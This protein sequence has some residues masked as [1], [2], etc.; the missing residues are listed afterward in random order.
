MGLS[1]PGITTPKGFHAAAGCCGIKPSGKPDLA[2][3][4]ADQPCS[5]A[6]VFTTNR[7]PSPSV[8]VAKRHVRSGT[9][10]AVVCNS[11][12]SNAATGNAGYADAVAMCRSVSQQA[13]SVAGRYRDV[14]PCSTGVIGPRLPMGKIQH[15][16]E[17]LAS[18]LGR[19][20]GVNDAVA[21]AIMTTDLSPK[22]AYTAVR[23]GG[24][25]GKLAR[26]GA[27]AK[28]SGMIAPNMATMLAFL[29][30][31]AAVAPRALAE[32]LRTAVGES[33]NRISIDQHTSPSDTVLVLAS[34][35][36]KHPRIQG[37][38]ADLDQ[39]TAALTDV[40]RD[41][42]YQIVGDGEGATKIFRVTVIG[43]KSLK[44][45]DRVGRTV[46]NSP[47]VKTAV[48]GGDPNWGR[49]V[50]AAGYSGAVIKPEK[51]SLT[52]GPLARASKGGRVDGSRSQRRTTARSPKN[53]CVYDQGHATPVD[54]SGAA[55]LERVM[56]GR[57]IEFTLDLGVGQAR[58]QWL[59]CDL[60]RDYV[61]I[62][63]DYT[64]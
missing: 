56:K 4:V 3:I 64:T 8:L 54:K 9:A 39:L 42:A 20:P 58:G 46:A 50:T 16:I 61:A 24:R 13:G 2:M 10:Q 52:I 23:I 48:H 19:G 15:G 18:R 31:D 14:L 35:L 34:G 36:A 44:D 63:A 5:A 57:Q 53:I 38:G 62:N 1:K 43:A 29:T 26:I 37:R 30:T 55:R 21:R 28:G 41:L 59:G 22:Q 11:G 25:H 7:V 45:A 6:G 40:C 51:L 33:F 49:I 47:L 32:A 12:V 17:D 60:S 27:V